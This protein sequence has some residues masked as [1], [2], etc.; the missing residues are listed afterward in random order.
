MKHDSKKILFKFYS[1]ALDE[2]MAETIWAKVVDK[3][4]GHFQIENIPFYVPNLATDDLVKAEYLEKEK[5]YIFKEIVQYSGNS[6]IRVIR[7][8][9]G[10]D[11]VELREKFQKWGCNSE[12]WNEDY[13]AMEIPKDV[14][15]NKI[16]KELKKL[17]KKEVISF[18]EAVLSD[19]HQK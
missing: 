17:E 5:T 18:A 1:E 12:K 9:K 19:A 7:L 16:R 2:H 6:I 15:Y 11:T 8:N 14:N 10:F 3:K 13:F 4:K